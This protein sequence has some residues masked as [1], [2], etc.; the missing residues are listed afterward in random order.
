MDQNPIYKPEPCGVQGLVNLLPVTEGTGG[1]VLVAHSHEHFP[2]HYINDT[3]YFYKERMTE[4]GTDDWLEVDANDDV[5]LQAR[6]VISC[7]LQPGDVLL[8]DSRTVHCSYPGK[9]DKK[10]PECCEEAHGL[11][12]AGVMV[13]MMPKDQ[14]DSY[15]L[16]ERVEAVHRS[17]TLTHWANKVAP[18]GEERPDQVAMEAS[19]VAG[20]RAWQKQQGK[21]VLL[22]YD[23]LTREQQHLV[24]GTHDYNVS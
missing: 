10:V 24:T 23:E 2:D 18:L 22:G 5:V 15:V 8:W 16:D 7:L 9:P 14:I 4:V 11:I 19:C 13:S 3:S 17:R 6:H 21:A 20:M 1:N 12:R